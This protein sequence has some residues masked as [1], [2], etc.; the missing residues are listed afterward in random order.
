MFHP[1]SIT[2]H[3][4]I[5][6]H[7]SMA[8]EFFRVHNISERKNIIL[9]KIRSKTLKYI[10]HRDIYIVTISQKK[11]SDFNALWPQNS[12]KTLQ[13]GLIIWSVCNFCILLNHMTSL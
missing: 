5:Y 2:N 13:R 11:E 3:Y 8:T 1:V 7:V 6:E 4:Q 9:D 12:N 10:F